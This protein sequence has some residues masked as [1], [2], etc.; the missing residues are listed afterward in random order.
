MTR[1]GTK[2]GQVWAQFRT[3]P[4]FRRVIPSSQEWEN[5]LELRDINGGVAERLNAAVLKTV[6]PK[7]SWGSNPCA[8]ASKNQSGKRINSLPALVFTVSF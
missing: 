4:L 8:S 6:E 2:R 5:M 3:R 1:L 7:G